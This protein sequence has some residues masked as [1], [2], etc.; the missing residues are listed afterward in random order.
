VRPA[1]DSGSRAQGVPPILDVLGTLGVAPFWLP[2][3]AGLVWPQMHAVAI[4]T[5]TSYAA[6][7]LSFLAGTR[8]G[9]AITQDRPA[10]TT[11]C[12]SMAPPI[13]AWA[14]ILLPINPAAR[15]V[16]LA[17]ALLAHAAWD[18]RASA[19]PDW[20]ARLRWRLTFGAMAGLLAGAVA[21][22]G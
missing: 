2:V 10:S 17:L 5:L 16:L 15:L 13:L 12:L 8:L 7:I 6:I 22:H 9:I 4:E 18:A 3:L 19:A 11:L 20:Y 14:L 21:L 1:V